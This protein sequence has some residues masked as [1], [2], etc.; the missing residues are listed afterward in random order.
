MRDIILTVLFFTCP[1]AA[2]L[3]TVRLIGAIFSQKIRSQIKMQPMIHIGWACYGYIGT[4]GVMK[5]VQL[6]R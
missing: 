2:L 1:I 6:A 4:F 5:L 3:F